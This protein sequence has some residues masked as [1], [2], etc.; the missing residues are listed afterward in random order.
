MISQIHDDRS[1]IMILH[2]Q[3]SWKYMYIL[4]C[5]LM[6]FSLSA[7]HSLFFMNCALCQPHSLFWP[8]QRPKLVFW[9]DFSAIVG[10]LNRQLYFNSDKNRRIYPRL[11]YTLILSS[12]NA[13]KKFEYKSHL[14]KNTRISYWKNFSIHA[15]KELA[16]KY[17]TVQYCCF[18][19]LNLYFIL[20]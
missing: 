5:S 3:T 17:V 20:W 15:H 1:R 18:R 6:I 13:E 7:F 8:C 4:S 19:Q 12:P 2:D 11:Y 16:Q 9:S 14:P 10:S